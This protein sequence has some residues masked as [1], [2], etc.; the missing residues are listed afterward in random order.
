MAMRT[1]GGGSRWVD[2]PPKP[3]RVDDH[4]LYWMQPP[5]E[6]SERC[7]YWAVQIARGF[8]RNRRWRYQGYDSECQLFGVYMWEWFNVLYPMLRVLE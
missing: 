4:Y 3:P 2:L 7:R 1:G 5:P 8:R 6:T